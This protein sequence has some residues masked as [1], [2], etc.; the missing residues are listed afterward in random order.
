M[1]VDVICEGHLDNSGERTHTLWTV[2]RWVRIDGKWTTT[3][4]ISEPGEPLRLLKD[5]GGAELLDGDDRI[6]LDDWSTGNRSRYR[7]RCGICPENLVRKKT[8]EVEA[9]LATLLDGLEA[10]GVPSI[11]LSA[12]RAKLR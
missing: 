9:K 5:A 6:A 8:P 7:F 4:R 10:N 3:K 11:S 2:A 1:S 12:L